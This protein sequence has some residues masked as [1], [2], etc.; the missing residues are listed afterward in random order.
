MLIKPETL[1]IQLRSIRKDDLP[2]LWRLMYDGDRTWMDHDAPY[3]DE[4]VPSLEDYVKQEGNRQVDNPHRLAI[5]YDDAVI[6]TV[7]AY[8][9]DGGLK[10]WLEVGIGIYD[11]K[12]W[13]KGIGEK[14]MRLYLTYLFDLYP[15]ICRIGVTTWSGNLGMMRLG[16]KLG[17]RQEAVIR[18]VR[19]WQGRYWDSIRYGILR[20][21][22]V[23]VNDE[24][25]ARLK[26]P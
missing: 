9:D 17:M 7:N 2:V 14:A 20:E 4:P 22:W 3:F 16:E 10:R 24:I 15:D 1:N 6:G 21:E 18:K 26:R 23:C 8:F 11:S 12:H 5:V 19:H 25:D 13:G